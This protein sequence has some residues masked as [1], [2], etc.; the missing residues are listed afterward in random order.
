MKVAILGSGNIGTD[1]L[2]KIMRSTLL[3]CGL[4]VGRR[5]DSPG[6]KKAKEVGVNI[7]DKGIEAIVNDPAC[8]EIVFDAT[9]A[10]DHL[11]HW[12]LLEKTV[13]FVVD[14]TPSKVGAMIVP[15]INLGSIKDHKDVNMVSCG[16][17][18]AIPLA[19]T[20]TQTQ[21]NI[22]YLEVVSSISSRSAGPGTR[23]NIDEYI[24]NTEEALRLFTK[25]GK[26]K[27]ILVL[28]PAQ[29]CIDMQTTISAKV[30]GPD[31]EKIRTAVSAMEKKIQA[32]VPGYKIVVPP[33]YE[34][35]RIVI[36]VRVRGLGDYL[37][38]YAG[39][40]DIINCAAIAAAEKYAAD[41][42]N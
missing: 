32:Y 13:K 11:T 4:F 8:C 21:P 24:E 40:L 41:I 25:C 30:K 31:M 23:I 12:P 3:E 20:L 22:E 26:V 1:L 34:N 17:Q 29:P 9:S 2:I 27:V 19:Y 18:A 28:N 36:M 5:L 38:S 15:A 10:R 39:N 16:G 33:V 14:M 42:N 6:M 37:P 7:S 35:N